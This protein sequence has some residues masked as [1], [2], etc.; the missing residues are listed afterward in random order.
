MAKLVNF[1]DAL[2]VMKVT[3]RE[4]DWAIE[5]MILDIHDLGKNFFMFDFFYV[6]RTFILWLLIGWQKRRLFVWVRLFVGLS[7]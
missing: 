6:P 2:E 1:S 4:K 7:I 5:P 3:K